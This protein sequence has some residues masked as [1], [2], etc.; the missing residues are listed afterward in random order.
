MTTMLLKAFKRG[1]IK[2]GDY[3]DY[4]PDYRKC[5]LSKE[6]GLVKPGTTYQVEKQILKTEDFKYQFAGII[7][8][9]VI[10]IADGVTNPIW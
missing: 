7:Y 9:Q 6:T 10:L 8:G 3:I 4:Q 1:H 2:E 5:I